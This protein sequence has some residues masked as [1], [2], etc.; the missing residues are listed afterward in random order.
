MTHKDLE[1]WKLSLDLVLNI[2]EI[3]KLFPD[4]EKFGL[5]SQVQPVK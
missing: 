3:T 2:Y 1:V 5:V 4:E